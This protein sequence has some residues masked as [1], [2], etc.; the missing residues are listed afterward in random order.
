MGKGEIK[1]RCLDLD[2][3]EPPINSTII[4]PEKHKQGLLCTLF[5]NTPEREV[6]PIINSKHP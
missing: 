3:P 4:F 2:K 5:N 6:D 1:V